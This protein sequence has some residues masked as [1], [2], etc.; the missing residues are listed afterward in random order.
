M[1]YVSNDPRYWLFISGTILVD[2]CEVVAGIVVVYDWVLTLDKRYVDVIAAA[3]I[4][5]RMVS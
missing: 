5:L 3:A 1:T 4:S 2:Y